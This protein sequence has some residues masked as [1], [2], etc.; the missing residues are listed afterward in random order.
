MNQI[1][2]SNILNKYFC[3]EC[4]F[5]TMYASCFARHSESK[6]HKSKTLLT[7]SDHNTI[8]DLLKKN[9]NSNF[10]CECGKVFNFKSGLSRHK[11][12]CID[13]INKINENDN[14]NNNLIYELIKKN[15]E[16]NDMVY[17]D[18]DTIIQILK[19]ALVKSNTNQ[20]NNINNITNNVGTINNTNVNM[21]LF[22]DNYCKDAVSINQFVEG[23]EVQVEDLLH[24]KDKG[25][26]QGISNIFINALKDMD[27]YKRPIHCSDLKRATLFIKDDETW[28]KGKE[29]REKL[30]TAIKHISQMQLKIIPQWEA[31]YGVDLNKEEMDNQY[32]KIVK[33]ATTYI[34]PNSKEED[35]II[36]TIAKEVIINKKELGVICNDEEDN[37]EDE[38]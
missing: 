25:I 9:N 31:T 22:L 34:E 2:I 17:K 30:S 27:I 37:N 14:N 28:T 29:S 12:I 6:R 19:D 20:T 35:K 21:M 10:L 16:L 7:K 15:H 18:K 38:E 24:T 23:L 32:A 36:K 11:K 33:K 13:S 3:E 4:N 1:K 5:Y 8:T 26:I